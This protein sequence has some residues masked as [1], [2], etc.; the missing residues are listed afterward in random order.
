VVEAYRARGLSL[1]VNV[2]M[3]LE[4]MEECGSEGLDRLVI[5]RA[6]TFLSDVDFFC[7]SDNYWLGKSKVRHP[8]PLDAPSRALPTA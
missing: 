7:I 8:P 1:P 3:I 2:K 5:D 4:G 6:P